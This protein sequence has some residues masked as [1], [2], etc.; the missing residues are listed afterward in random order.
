MFRRRCTFR[1][2]SRVSGAVLVT[3]SLRRELRET[4]DAT[5]SGCPPTSSDGH[6]VAMPT[7]GLFS[8]IAPV[9]PWNAA[10]PKLKIPPSVAT[11]Q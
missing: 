2:L 10:S 1:F 7:I 5:R 6:V 3:T 9:E 11:S 4:S 8:A